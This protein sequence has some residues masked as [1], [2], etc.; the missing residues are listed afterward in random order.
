MSENNIPKKRGRK[1][2]NK[3]NKIIQVSNQPQV[4]TISLAKADNTQDIFKL[5]NKSRI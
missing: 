2:K 3:N 4:K 1:P 5:F